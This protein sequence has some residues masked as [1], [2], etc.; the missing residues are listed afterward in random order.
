MLAV[1]D[2]D[3]TLLDS[4]ST[5]LWLWDRARRSLP[6]LLAILLVAPVAIP[7]VIAPRTRRTGASI[8]LWIA[9]VG[10]DERELQ[11]S[12]AAFASRFQ[13]GALPLR[14]RRQGVETLEGHFARGDEVVVVT[15][16]PTVLAQSLIGPLDRP[17]V[18]LGT[19]LKR[20]AGG[21]VADVHCRHQRKCQALAEAGH[22][23]RWAYAYTDSLDDLPLLRGA[24]APMIV[25]CGKAARRRLGRARLPNGRA[26][27]W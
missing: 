13:A 20:Q 22:G 4:D 7:M 26:M 19:S 3:G 17:I 27:A 10:L 8:L 23:P 15:A 21:W 18:V 11:D 12:C 16:A 1:F 2:L 24:D 25:G 6:R 9:T 14:W 5:A